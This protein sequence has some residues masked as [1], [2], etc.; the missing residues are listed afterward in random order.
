MNNENFLKLAKETEKMHED[1][2][3]KYAELKTAMEELKIGTYLQD[4]ETL[5][6]YKII[7]PTGTY[8]EFRNIDYKRTALDGERGGSVLSKKEA[9]LQGFIL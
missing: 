9:E 3:M 6:V 4:P 1:L 7:Q 2:K 8:V 5:T